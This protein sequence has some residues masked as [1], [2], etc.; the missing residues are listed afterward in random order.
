[1]Q[2]RREQIQAHMFVMGRLTSGLLRTDLDAPES[3]VGR[4]NRGLAIGII[5]ALLV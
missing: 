3:P 1:M 2:N 4:T 5:V